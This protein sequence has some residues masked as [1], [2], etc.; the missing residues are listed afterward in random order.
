[1]HSHHGHTRKRHTV[2]YPDVRTTLQTPFPPLS[3]PSPPLP[4]PSLL[5]CFFSRALTTCGTQALA[6][7]VAIDNDSIISDISLSN[8]GMSPTPLHCA[9][10]SLVE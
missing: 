1:M 2:I 10:P 3:P 6:A 9:P 5:L 4:S 8:D 7:S